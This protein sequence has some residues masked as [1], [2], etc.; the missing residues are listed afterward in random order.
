MSA[1]ATVGPSYVVFPLGERRFALPTAD[2]VELTR[3]G[4]I[5]EFPHT[6]TALDGVLVR[7]GEVLPVWN[8]ARSLE[9]CSEFETRMWLVT[10]RNF[11]TDELTAIPV[12]GECQMFPAPALHTS[13]ET[14]SRALGILIVDDQPIEVLDLRRLRADG[15]LRD[16]ENTQSDE[17][18]KKL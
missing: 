4:R 1:A 14:P 2:V 13:S 15:D 10:R 18:G 6:S 3:H 9:G 8:L 12:S 7:R 16:S 5:Q 17:E 11:E